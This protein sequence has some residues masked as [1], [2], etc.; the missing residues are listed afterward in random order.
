MILLH[1]KMEFMF[2]LLELSRLLYLP[3]LIVWQKLCD[4]QARSQKMICL[5][6]NSLS[7]RIYALG[8]Q[9]LQVTRKKPGCSEASMLETARGETTQRNYTRGETTLRSFTYS[10]FLSLPCPGTTHDWRKFQDDPSSSYHLKGTLW[11]I[12]IQ[13]HPG[14][15]LPNSGPRKTVKDNKHFKSLSLGMTSSAAIDN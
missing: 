14:M 9:N 2:C 15:V 7:L 4:S 3:W 8:D 12:L 6:P 13:N 11:E 1:W 10:K 5:L